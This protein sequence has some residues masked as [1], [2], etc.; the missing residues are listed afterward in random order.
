MHVVWDWNGT[1][2]DDLPIVLASVNVGI[3][4]YR[5]TPVT[6]DDY[7]T[8]YTRP[9]KRFYDS[10]LGRDISHTEWVD[11]DHRFHIAYRTQ[12]G[13]AQLA[14]GA[15]Q[16]L[17]RTSAEGMSQSLLS[18]YPHGELLPLVAAVGIDH[19]FDR[20]DG[21]RGSPGDRKAD[22]LADHLDELGADPGDTLVVGDT[23][24]DAHAATEVGADCVLV[25][26]GGHHRPALESS[27]VRIANGLIEAI[28]PFVGGW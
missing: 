5:S 17:E 20:I 12:L 9:V 27:G 25:D 4:P 14:A 21:L 2:L 15:M 23:P 18:M 13:E 8:H 6:L 3:E 24:D 1:L 7:R 19:H 11:L 16:V 10:L 28:A 22:Y 26:N